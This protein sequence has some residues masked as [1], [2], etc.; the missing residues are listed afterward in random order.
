MLKTTLI[1]AKNVA[2]G[3]RS[4]FVDFSTLNVDDQDEDQ[5]EGQNVFVR[6]QEIENKEW[7]AWRSLFA[8]QIFP[9]RHFP[10][11]RDV[12]LRAGTLPKYEHS[13]HLTQNVPEILPLL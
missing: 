8:E 1:E 5:K 6:M 13:I 9:P 12:K 3:E 2:T 10:E 11:R 7:G 4:D